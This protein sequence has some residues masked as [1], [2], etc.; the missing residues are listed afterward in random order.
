MEGDWAI[1]YSNFCSYKDGGGAIGINSDPR[2]PLF[3]VF[4]KKMFISVVYL[5]FPL[6]P[7]LLPYERRLN[8]C[9]QWFNAFK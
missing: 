9:F 6:A 5:E 1:G 2:V 4:L 7:G 8:F 3:P